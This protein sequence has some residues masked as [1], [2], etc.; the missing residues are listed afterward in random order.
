[1]PCFRL[2]PPAS[3]RGHPLDCNR[4]LSCSPFVRF[5]LTTGSGLRLHQIAW[6]RLWLCRRLAP[7][8][9]PPTLL[10]CPPARLAPC[11]RT[12]RPHLRS[13]RQLAPPT[14]APILLSC[15]A[16]RLASRVEPSGL[17]FDPRRLAPVV[18][19]GSASPIALR[20]APLLDRSA[21]PSA[22]FVSLRREPRFRI[23]L[24]ASPV[25]L[26]LPGQPFSLPFGCVDRLAPSTEL[27]VLPSCLAARLALCDRPFS[28]T[29]LPDRRFPDCLR[30][31]AL[32]SVSSS[33]LASDCAAGPSVRFDLRPADC[34][35]S[36]FTG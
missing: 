5:C 27:P 35:L 29:F 14:E 25:G 15:P 21:S 10:S 17:A 28:L 24:P 20:L 22:L 16:F 36:G 2:A 7:W 12:F 34:R 30:P 3:L 18:H 9:E 23:C 8:T 26:R 4:R 32:P 1:M 19:S 6:P 31:L 13:S 11:D 33:A